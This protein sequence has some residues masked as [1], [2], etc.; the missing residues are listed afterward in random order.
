[1]FITININNN[2]SFTEI[3]GLW[4]LK[5]NKTEQHIHTYTTNKMYKKKSYCF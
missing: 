5:R 1:M 2:N 3:S 4:K